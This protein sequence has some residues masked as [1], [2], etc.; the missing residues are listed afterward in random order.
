MAHFY[1]SYFQGKTQQNLTYIPNLETLTFFRMNPG[2]LRL[3][4]C[5]ISRLGRTCGQPFIATQSDQKALYFEN[6][7]F[8]LCFWSIPTGCHIKELTID[9]ALTPENVPQVVQRNDPKYLIFL[10]V[11]L[12]RQQIFVEQAVLRCCRLEYLRISLFFL[13]PRR[14]IR[15]LR[16]LRLYIEVLLNYF[17]VRN[18]PITVAFNSNQIFHGRD[19]LVRFL[20]PYRNH[21]NFFVIDR[22][23][24][25]FGLSWVRVFGASNLIT[26][27]DLFQ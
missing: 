22:P 5:R 23:R 9:W 24:H 12:S 4:H 19:R 13:V 11:K 26:I 6:C 18:R 14:S 25:G 8:Q 10:N 1:N 2:Y 7:S 20:H 27:P 17:I 3:H 15:R 21:V 16:A